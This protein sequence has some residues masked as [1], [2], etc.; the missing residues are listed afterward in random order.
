MVERGTWKGI[1]FAWDPR[2]AAFCG[3]LNLASKAYRL[4]YREKSSGNTEAWI[5]WEGSQYTRTCTMSTVG[6]ALDGAVIALEDYLQETMN[7]L[8]KFL[9]K[10]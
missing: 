4:Y 2:R 5:E 3:V 10:A 1:G 6:E 9:P 7:N 8:Q